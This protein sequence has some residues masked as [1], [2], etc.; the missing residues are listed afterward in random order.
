[1]NEQEALICKNDKIALI[2][3]PDG[4]QTYE[5]RWCGEWWDCPQCSHSVLYPSADL[6]AFLAE[7][8]APKD[9]QEVMDFVTPAKKRKVSKI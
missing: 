5:Q 4:Q 1:M 7:Q 2:K 3:R 6:T 8:T 9:T